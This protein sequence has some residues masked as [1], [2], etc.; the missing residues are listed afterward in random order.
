VA[1]RGWV[2][3]EELAELVGEELFRR[4]C[5]RAWATADA[6]GRGP[7]E[8]WPA[9]EADLPHILADF[10][11]GDAALGLALYRVMPCYAVLMYVGHEPHDDAFWR[12][13]VRIL[14]DP[15]DRLAAPATYWLWR[16]PFEDTEH[17]GRLWERLT[18]GAGDRRLRR[19][20]SCSGPVPWSAK[21]ALLKRLSGLSDWQLPVFG[22]LESAA[23]DIFGSVDS[24][25]AKE[26]LRRLDL[27]AGR[28]EDLR[29]RLAELDG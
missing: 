25:A 24:G 15:D 5:E 20:L 8:G 7:S 23:Y 19:L 9:D 27:P 11:I 16:G 22:A 29:L 2:S 26:V 10:L 28:T 4:T 6:T 3:V 1:D 13:M 18:E 12:E 17:A 14:D 21:G